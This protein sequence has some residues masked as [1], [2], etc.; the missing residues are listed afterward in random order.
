MKRIRK[1]RA[2]IQS[3][4][5]ASSTGTG[6]MVW[7]ESFD[8][9]TRRYTEKKSQMRMRAAPGDSPT[10]PPPVGRY[11]GISEKTRGNE[12]RQD[13]A[14]PPPTKSSSQSSSTLMRP[15][16]LQI[17]KE[18][19]SGMIPVTIV[20]ESP[21]R[22][23][24]KKEPPKEPP[25]QKKT[26]GAEESQQKVVRSFSKPLSSDPPKLYIFPKVQETPQIPV[27]SPRRSQF[28][29]EVRDINLNF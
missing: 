11:A 13:R 6:A 5:T 3:P 16:P 24:P 12:T 29:R 4:D 21:S 26:T 20:Q 25:P 10:L 8:G 28:P 9:P 17:V 2:L 27:K 18:R 23:P 22:E 14:A 15:A 7:E 19:N 1:L